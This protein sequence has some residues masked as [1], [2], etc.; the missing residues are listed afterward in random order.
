MFVVYFIIFFFACEVN[1]SQSIPY[2]QQGVSQFQNGQYQEAVDSFNNVL[3]NGEQSA[4]VYYNLGNAYYKLGQI[5]RAV[6][7]YERAKRLSPRDPDIL[8]NL[9]IAQLRVVDKI[10]TPPPMLFLKLWS[11]F[12]EIISVEFSSLLFMVF[13]LLF[14]FFLIVKLFAKNLVIQKIVRFSFL[15]LLVLVFISGI[16]FFLRARSE[17]NVQ[18]G[19]IL[20]N[21]VEVKSSPSPEAT[22]VFALHEGLKVQITDYSGNFVRIELPDGKVGWLPKEIIELITV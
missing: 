17:S 13:Y 3:K 21:K 14:I 16:L 1:A 15:P 19:V 10:E 22:D 2:F 18:E 11:D 12:T 5:G 6:L 8:Y 4:A 20:V 9:E 7:N